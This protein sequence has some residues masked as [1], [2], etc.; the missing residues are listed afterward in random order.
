MSLGGN[1]PASKPRTVAVLAEMRTL[2][3]VTSPEGFFFGIVAAP[4]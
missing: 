4:R 3:G 2:W 1:P